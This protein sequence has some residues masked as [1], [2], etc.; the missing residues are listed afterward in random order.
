MLSSGLGYI[1]FQELG[2]GVLGL[3]VCFPGF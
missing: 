1:N 2:R 3:I